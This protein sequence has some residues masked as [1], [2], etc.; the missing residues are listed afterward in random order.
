MII[1]I[2]ENNVRIGVE[3]SELNRE[4]GFDDDIRISLSELG[5]KEHQR[6]FRGD[7]ISFLVTPAQ[8][9]RIGH[10]LLDAAE[11]SRNTPKD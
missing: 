9:D 8:A 11:E 3:F 10:A 2:R 7:Q 6:L 1:D 4:K 5:P